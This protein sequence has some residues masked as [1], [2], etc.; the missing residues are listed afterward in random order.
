VSEPAVAVSPQF[1]SDEEED[2][3][4]LGSHKYMIAA[5]VIA[6]MIIGGLLL[7]R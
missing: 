5:I 1:L 6:L 2:V 4:W 3:S 7:A